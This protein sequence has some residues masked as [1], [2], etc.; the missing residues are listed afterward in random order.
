M[1]MVILLLDLHKHYFNVHNVMMVIFQIYL[2]V[3]VIVV[4]VIVNN[5]GNIHKH[6]IL[7]NF[8]LIK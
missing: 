5:V 6:T 1:I 3:I 4:L 7:Q 8:Y 2:Q